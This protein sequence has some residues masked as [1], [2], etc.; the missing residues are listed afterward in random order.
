MASKRRNVHF[1]PDNVDIVVEQGTNLLV[2]T[3]ANRVIEEAL[4]VI[5]NKIKINRKIPEL[6]DGKVAERIVKILLERFKK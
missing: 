3:D 6:W 1:S 4:K 5:D 2:S